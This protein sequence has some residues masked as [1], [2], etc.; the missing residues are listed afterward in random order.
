MRINQPEDR[1]LEPR[2]QAIERSMPQLAGQQEFKD[3]A[4]AQR[5]VKAADGP[6]CGEVGCCSH[7]AGEDTQMPNRYEIGPKSDPD[8]K[9]LTVVWVLTAIVCV[10]GLIWISFI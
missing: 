6:T 10:C 4:G 1:I 5:P 8:P 3:P 9:W 7:N 2:L